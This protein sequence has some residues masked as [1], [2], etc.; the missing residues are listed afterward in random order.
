MVPQATAESQQE[1]QHDQEEADMQQEASTSQQQ[2]SV[3]DDVIGRMSHYAMPNIAS[4]LPNY[5]NAEQEFVFRTFNVGNYDLLKHLPDTLK[6]QQV[7]HGQHV[8]LFVHCPQQQHL[9]L[10]CCARPCLS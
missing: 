5:S 7:Q 4:M 10:S 2:P 1:Q 6:E 3:Q 8:K 9:L